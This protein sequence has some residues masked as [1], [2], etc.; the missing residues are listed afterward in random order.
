[1]YQHRSTSA[2]RYGARNGPTSHS[3]EV[4]LSDFT[5]HLKNLFDIIDSECR[6]FVSLEELKTH[7]QCQEV[8]DNKPRVVRRKQDS[9]N[10]RIMSAL[11]QIAPANGLLNFKR[12]SLAM[13]VAL[14]KVS[15]DPRRGIGR[16]LRPQSFMVA[17]TESSENETETES[18]LDLEELWKSSTS[19]N[20]NQKKS[21]KEMKEVDNKQNNETHCKL[22]FSCMRG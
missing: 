20:C 16:S 3:E 14:G 10:A 13:K 2:C 22:T 6:G 11:N 4:E 9:Q 5:L 18:E 12:F 15:A 21:N 17:V 7:L 1:M 19:K 8:A